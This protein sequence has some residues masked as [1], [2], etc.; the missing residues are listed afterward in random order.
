MKSTKRLEITTNKVFEIIKNFYSENFPYPTQF[1]AIDAIN[2][3]FSDN[4]FERSV[5]GHLQ[6][7]VNGPAYVGPH[8]HY[9][10]VFND[11]NL[12]IDFVND[13]RELHSW[14]EKNGFIEADV[15]TEKFTLTNKL[16][17]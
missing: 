7:N 8:N 2:L 14:L 1:N 4:T 6:N 15:A 13:V 10:P 5:K 3:A 16:Y 11:Q 12:C 9:T 17:F